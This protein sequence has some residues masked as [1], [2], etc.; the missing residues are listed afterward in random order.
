MDVYW[1]KFYLNYVGC[2]AFISYDFCVEVICFTLTMWDVKMLGNVCFT[3]KL[4]F[5]LN[6]V[7]CK[8]KTESDKPLRFFVLP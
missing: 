2:K 7:G 6:Y 4:Q 3:R 5:Y 8:G 1:K